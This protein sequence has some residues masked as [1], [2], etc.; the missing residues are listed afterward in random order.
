MERTAKK[1]VVEGVANER[2]PRVWWRNT[3]GPFVAVLDGSKTIIKPNERFQARISEVSRYFRD[4]VIPLESISEEERGLNAPS[5]APKVEYKKVS[6]KRSK[7][8]FDVV[9]LNGKPLNGTPLS[10][11]EADTLIADLNR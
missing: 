5:K 1:I 9:G 2:D 6:H 8:F 10:E 3:G 4:V 11:E 7:V